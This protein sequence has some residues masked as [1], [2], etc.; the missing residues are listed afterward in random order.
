MSSSPPD[1]F[2]W[3]MTRAIL[4]NDLRRRAGEI[5]RA[6]ERAVVRQLGTWKYGVNLDTRGPGATDIVAR[7]RDRH[8]LVQVKTSQTPSLPGGLSREEERAIR[9][10]AERL[11]AEPS[12]GT[13]SRGD[14]RTRSKRRQKHCMAAI[15]DRCSTCCTRGGRDASGHSHVR[16]AVE[17]GPPWTAPSWGPG[18][19]QCQRRC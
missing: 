11:G 7:G 15:P 4:L 6:G 5:G 1:G 10:R 3:A 16:T 19:P 8:L 14:A 18:D 13:S 2:F 12:R 9:S 17:D